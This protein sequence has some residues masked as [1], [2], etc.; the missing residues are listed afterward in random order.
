MRSLYEISE[1]LSR[2]MEEAIAEAEESDGEITEILNAKL[3]GLEVEKDLKV[4]NICRYY[5]SLLAESDMVKDEA[6]KL[7]ERARVTENKAKSLKN[8]LAMFVPEGEKFADEHSKIGWRKSES[9][10]IAE[11][12][13][14]DNAPDNWKRVSVAWD[15]T[16]IKKAIKAGEKMPDEIQL[17]QKQNIQIK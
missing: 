1:D 16:E 14:F 17:A 3:D 8:Y 6:K 7:S 2:C 11:D 12:Y 13:S 4:G 15:K 10:F 5:K 9:L